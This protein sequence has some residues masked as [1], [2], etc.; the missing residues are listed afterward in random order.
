MSNKKLIIGISGF[1]RSGKDTAA[2]IIDSFFTESGKKVK[3]FSFAYALKSDINDFS[4]EKIGISSFIEDSDLK[5]KI[6]PILI[7]YGAVKRTLS[8]GRYWLDKIKPEI[9]TFFE[10]GGDIAIISDL[11]FKEFDFDEYDLIRSYEN[12]LVINISRESE[13]GNLIQ[14]AHESEEKNQ[15]FFIKNSD[16]LLFWKSSQDK[17]YLNNQIKDIISTIESKI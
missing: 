16:K 2:S 11:R 5:S 10:G 6:R 8:N 14:A 7:A 9:D 1:A 13:N 15:P 4:I 3:I 17:I 12:N